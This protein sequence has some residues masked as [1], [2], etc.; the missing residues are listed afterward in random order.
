MLEGI[1]LGGVFFFGFFFFFFCQTLLL[2]LAVG[3][4]NRIEMME[5]NN[6]ALG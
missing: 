6:S 1:V 4:L 2:D 5:V 3:R